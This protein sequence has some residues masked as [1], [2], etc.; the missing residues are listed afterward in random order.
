MSVA[1]DSR[2]LTSR[3]SGVKRAVHRM[4]RDEDSIERRA[5][6][7]CVDRFRTRVNF[8]Y[9]LQRRDDGFTHATISPTVRADPRGRRRRRETDTDIS[10]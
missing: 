3:L 10:F 4:K 6:V 9:V 1:S 2:P 7:W 8:T 5:V